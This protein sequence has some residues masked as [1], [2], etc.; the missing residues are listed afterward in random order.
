MKIIFS[1]KDIKFYERGETFKLSQELGW[2]DENGNIY[3]WNKLPR[4]QK[5]GVLMHEII[6]YLLVRLKIPKRIS[7][8][9]ANTMEKILTLGNPAKVK[10]EK[11]F[12]CKDCLFVK[13]LHKAIYY[14]ELESS[15]TIKSEVHPLQ[16]ACVHFQPRRT[17][18]N[19]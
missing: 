18:G 6:E 5:F 16:P 13:K 11:S 12:S 2:W 4:L 17:E 3:V 14:C 10:E 9:I 1:D 19:P 7:H 15:K 8:H